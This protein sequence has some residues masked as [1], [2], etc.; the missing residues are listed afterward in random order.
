[1]YTHTHTHTRQA[2]R[3]ASQIVI[4]KMWNSV[5]YWKHARDISFIV[6][7]IPRINMNFEY[8]AYM[9]LVALWTKKYRIKNT[10]FQ[11]TNY[12]FCCSENL[13]CSYA[14]ASS[15][16]KRK[17]RMTE[18]IC[19]KP[20]NQGDGSKNEIP[21]LWLKSFHNLLFLLPIKYLLFTV[22]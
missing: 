15:L 13:W 3:I 21:V 7:I 6:T 9:L 17:L 10:Y 20:C 5:S 8:F 12:N 22:L 2:S 14:I 16:Q 1:M 4:W 19:L 18:G 11:Y